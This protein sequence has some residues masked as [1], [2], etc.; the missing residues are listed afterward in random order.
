MASLT[1]LDK[2]TAKRYLTGDAVL[3]ALAMRQQPINVQSGSYATFCRVNNLQI[4]ALQVV[5]APAVTWPRRTVVPA[6][7]FPSTRLVGCSPYFVYVF[8]PVCQGHNSL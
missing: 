3:P 5:G 1:S 7:R 2:P 8:L 4:S 6:L